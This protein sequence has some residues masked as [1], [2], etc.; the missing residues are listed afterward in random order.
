MKAKSI[1]AFCCQIHTIFSPSGLDETENQHEEPLELQASNLEI[2]ILSHVI[3]LLR[4]LSLNL[5]QVGAKTNS[6]RL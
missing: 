3:S 2:S 6:K 5:I 1:W 4:F